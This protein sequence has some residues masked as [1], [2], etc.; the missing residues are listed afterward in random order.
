MI[1]TEKLISSVM[2]KDERKYIILAGKQSCEMAYDMLKDIDLITTLRARRQLANLRNLLYD[3]NLSEM[4]KI[5]AIPFTYVDEYNSNKTDSHG[6]F[7]GDNLK[8]TVSQVRSRSALPRSARFRSEHSRNN[9]FIPL[10]PELEEQNN[11][12][13]IYAILTFGAVKNNLKFSSFGI[14]QNGCNGWTDDPFVMY[15]MRKNMMVLHPESPE[16]EKILPNLKGAK[17]FVFDRTSV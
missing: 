6:F 5:N 14:P 1:S 9:I 17:E 10:F 12:D 7:V 15:E 16:E 13:R 11:D 4:C 3:F 2:S 8:F